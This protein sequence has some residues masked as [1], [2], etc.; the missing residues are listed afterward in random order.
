MS[1]VV[2]TAFPV[3]ENRAE[4]I[5]TSEAAIARVH[6]EPRVERARAGHAKGAALVGLRST[7][8]GKF[9][10]GLAR[11]SS[12]RTRPQAR[13]RACFHRSPAGHHRLAG[14]PRL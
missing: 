8:E 7:S 1:V 12:S 4:V 11:R 13:R 3:P 5:A 14:G 6:C 2:V 10:H 9:S